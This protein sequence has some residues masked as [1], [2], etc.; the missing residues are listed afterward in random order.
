MFAKIKSMLVNDQELTG[1]NQRFVSIIFLAIAGGMS[2]LE[3]THIGWF[4]DYHLTFTPGLISTVI[5]TL[6]IAPLYLRGILIWNKSVYTTISFVLILLV[7]A[8]F[9]ELALGG[10]SYN[11]FVMGTIGAALLLS[12]LGIKEAAGQS[13]ALALVA[14]LSSAILNDMAMGFYGFIYIACGVLGL[15]IH[16]KLNP[17]QL[18]AGIR[19]AY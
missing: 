4:W 7:F 6:M 3:Y 17:G 9:L 19:E 16:S 18:V 14:G 2:F 13:W 10:N 8:S 1:E 12:W 5:A 15:L 11:P